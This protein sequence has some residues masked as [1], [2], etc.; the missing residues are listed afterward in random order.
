MRFTALRLVTADVGVLARFYA[1]VTGVAAVGSDEYVELRVAG[2]TL[3]ICS[4]S[5]GRLFCGGA[6]PAMNRSAI[7]DF[8]V[9][10]VD[11]ERAR[12]EGIVLDWVLPP[13]TQPWGNRS[14]LFRDPDGNL[15][16]L[17]AR[18]PVMAVRYCRT[19][20]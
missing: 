11:A 4:A 9:E 19:C 15:V 1:A 16:N 8:E 3:S 18:A 14:M 2:A 13:A 20:G 7:L 5:A 17:F 6:V 10:D 12:L